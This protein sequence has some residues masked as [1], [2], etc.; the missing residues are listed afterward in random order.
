MKILKLLNKVHLS[1]FIIIISLLTVI[2]LKAEEELVDIWKIE[3]KEKNKDNINEEEL[4]DNSTI[5]NSTNI[6]N[7]YDSVE[8]IQNLELED[9]KIIL[10][11]I[12]DPADN[13]LSM[14]MW[15]NSDGNEIIK[16]FNRLKKVKLSNDSKKI[17][18]IALLTNSYFPKKNMEEEIFLNFKFD[19]LIDNKNLKLIETYLLKN[20]NYN[21]NRI[22]KFYI[23]HYLSNS[24]LKNACKIL[25]DINLYNDNY[26]SKFKIY[27]LINEN[28]KEEAQLIF[29]LVKE[30][31][32]EDKFFEKKFNLLMGY[33]NEN[34]N[35]LSDKNIL[36]FHLSHRVNSD[37][38][39]KPN[40]NTSKIIWK[41]LSTS[42]LLQNVGEIDLENIEEISI[43]ENATHEKIYEEKDLLE[44]YKRFQFNINQLITAKDNF[45]LLPNYEGRA[46]LY[47]RILLSN[48]HEDTIELAS[49]LKSSFIEDNIGD[50][51]NLE[52]SN[53]LSEINIENVPAN[54]STFYQKY[55]I[56]ETSEKEKIK[57]NNKIIHQ[58]K[59]LNYFQG[60]SDEKKLK[61]DLADILKNV[62]K[63]KKY[64]V[65][66]KDYMI[67]DSLISDGFEIPKK[68]QNLFELNQSVIPNDIT[69]LINNNEIGLVLLRIAE[70]IGE[71]KLQD[72]G[73]E[74]VYF[75]ISILNEL[76]LD[77]IR[78]EIILKVLP[79]KI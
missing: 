10:A 77:K 37:L 62:K 17:L 7:D 11:G 8:I 20:N 12:Y 49:K 40:K 30:I 44:L 69:L 76:N 6:T 78:N 51:F 16:I 15:S 28:K 32:F 18:D 46:L 41:Y 39:Y 38:N 34:D 63:N 23:N 74:T 57:I 52:L 56:D 79:L 60:K 61:K 25:K 64:F 72:I 29:D 24:D 65:S 71:D 54:Y 75:M 73:P 5:N 21:N 59:L 67:L 42:N 58:S 43:I 35:E 19:Y 31:G 68:Y 9:N 1:I 36:D 53:I 3:K 26:L 50:A 33:I 4:F 14:E 47:Q 45:K 48:S 70:F 22:I 27:C 66:S 13:G 2:D 55:L